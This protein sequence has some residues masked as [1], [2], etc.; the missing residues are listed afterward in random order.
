MYLSIIVPTLGRSTELV[1]ALQSLEPMITND[2]EV[3]IIDQNPEGFLQRVIPAD[4][5]A[6]ISIHHID[7]KG[8]S[9]AR[10][11]GIA[12]ASGEF[13]NFCDDDAVVEPELPKRIAAGFAK[14][15]QASMISFRVFDLKEDVVCMIPFPEADCRIDK[16]NYFVTSIEF[17]HVWRTEDI[18]RLGG[19][20]PLLGVGA[21]FGAEEARD[22]VVR[23]LD[24][25]V[26]MVYIADTAFRHP[27]KR[28]ANVK[29]YFSYA[30]GM[31]GFA[32]KHWKK[33]YVVS[34]VAGFL[35]KSVVGVVVFNVWKRGESLRYWMRL[36]GFFS[37]IIKK[38]K[39]V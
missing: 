33:P 2:V 24:A 29:R 17:S 36:A 19:Y 15:P 3:I 31:A 20:D 30:E 9:N 16:R 39:G 21:P 38:I 7:E 14:Y 26:A 4:L 11:A 18:R 5:Q 12:L 27:T 6:K 37:G 22:L 32:C 8:A 34:R 10:N 35:F 1:A 25:N 28:D 23:A 13:I